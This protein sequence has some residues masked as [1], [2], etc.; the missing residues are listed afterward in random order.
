[1]ARAFLSAEPAQRWGERM[2][3]SIMTISM[4]VRLLQGG[5]NL[6]EG[7]RS[8][9]QKVA[10]AGFEKVDITSLELQVLGLDTV[11]LAL[12]E[13]GLGACSYIAFERF[14]QTDEPPLETRI[15]QSKAAADAAAALG[16]EVLM[17]APQAGDAIG[18]CTQEQLL[19]DM[20]ARWRPAARYAK[21]LGLHPVVE[22]TPDQ[23]LKLLTPAELTALLDAAPE[24][25]VVFDSGNALLA[26]EDPAAYYSKV[27]PRTTHVH[28]KDMVE[29]GPGVPMT[30]TALDG[31]KLAGAPL[32]TGLVDLAA[33]AAA[34][35]R[36][37]YQG[38]YTL[39]YNQDPGLTEEE[40]LRRHWLLAKELLR[41]A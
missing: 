2:K 4:V 29:A 5:G 27:A 40:A 17:L 10:A 39:E 7:Y 21:T 14:A 3:V 6:A 9:M 19:A 36:A 26:L 38:W 20:A 15:A 30:D 18:A 41:G 8:M 13:A 24:L 1:M 16:A 37:G 11:R 12:Q 35:Q 23:R 33:F 28:L 22:N 25:E 31:R 34:T 32:G